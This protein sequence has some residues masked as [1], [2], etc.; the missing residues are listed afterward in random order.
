MLIFPLEKED[1][2]SV[3][4]RVFYHTIPFSSISEETLSKNINDK[5]IFLIP[6]EETQNPL[7]ET[8]EEDFIFYNNQ[9]YYNVGLMGTL[10]NFETNE[11]EL[12]FCEF[13]LSSRVLIN[14]TNSEF[15]NIDSN[16]ILSQ[17]FDITYIEDVVDLS[18]DNDSVKYFMSFLDT[19]KARQNV[20]PDSFYKTLHLPNIQIHQIMDS[21]AEIMLSNPSPLSKYITTFYLEKRIILL[22]QAVMSYMTKLRA[23][24]ITQKNKS[25]LPSPVSE[26]IEDKISNSLMPKQ[27]K[28]I[29][30]KEAQRLEIIPSASTEYS[31]LLTYIEETLSLPW[32]KYSEAKI[33]LKNFIHDLNKSHYGLEEVKTILLGHFCIEELKQN[34][35]G[36]VLCFVGPPGTGKTSIAKQIAY[37]S[38]RQFYPMALGGLSDESELRGFK[39]A[40]VGAQPGRIAKALKRTGTMNPL[41]LLDEIDKMGYESRGNPAAALLEILDPEQNSHFVDRYFD[42]EIPLDKC[43]FICTANDEKSIPGPLKDR[44]ECIY[45][46][47]YTFDEKL[48]IIQDYVIPK[49]LTQFNMKGLDIKIT[50]KYLNTLASNTHVRQI[51]KRIQADLRN[52]AIDYLIN[53]LDTF[54]LDDNKQTPKQTTSIGFGRNK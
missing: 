11:E 19:I 48:K 46:R 30:L 36:T 14:E 44:M 34:S 54:I 10:N 49:T 31:N 1:T 53:S 29:L 28:E 35:S 17:N 20:F 39:R 27:Q 38:N 5:V 50:E 12:H 51:E 7:E 13:Y 43:I 40:Y 6:Y 52:I 21:I 9:K 2:L 32:G 26:K 25:S 22:Q 3:P 16:P 37:N 47:E 4:D 41:F 24:K 45:F 33:D 23:Q 18:E 15:S 8:L 42:L